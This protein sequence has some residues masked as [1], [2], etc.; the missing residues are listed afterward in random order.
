MPGPPLKIKKKILYLLRL[1]S[2]KKAECLAGISEGLEKAYS[3]LG[4][5]FWS[6]YQETGKVASFGCIQSCPGHGIGSLATWA[7]KH[8]R[9]DGFSGICRRERH[10][11]EFMESSNMKWKRKWQ[12][13]P[14][15]LPGKFH[16][17]GSLVG[18][19][20]ESQ[21]VGLD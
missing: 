12:S 1:T 4:L 6:I 11:V 3:T 13:S 2:K 9:S 5:L 21:R 17:Q 7:R 20:M 10:S 19:F 14:V 16:G 18:F 15:F 8:N